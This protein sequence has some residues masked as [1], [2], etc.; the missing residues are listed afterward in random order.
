MTLLQ[1]DS[2]T[3]PFAVVPDG[4]AAMSPMNRKNPDVTDSGGRFG[5]DVIAGYYK[6][7]AEKSGCHAPSAA[8]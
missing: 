7:R 5:W 2:A 4:S 6:V 3:G 8:D 1:S